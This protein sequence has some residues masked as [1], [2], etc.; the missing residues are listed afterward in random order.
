M[1]QFVRYILTLRLLRSPALSLVDWF[2]RFTLCFFFLG[3]FCHRSK[4]AVGCSDLVVHVYDVHTGQVI[5]DL[6]GHAKIPWVLCFHPSRNTV[7]ASGCLGGQVRVWD[8]VVSRRLSK[9]RLVSCSQ[10]F[11]LVDQLRSSAILVEM[12][13]VRCKFK[14]F[15]YLNQTRSL[16]LMTWIE[17]EEQAFCTYDYFQKVRCLLDGLSN[18]QFPWWS[19]VHVIILEFAFQ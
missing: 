2:F 4:L 15:L 6:K 19:G 17:V 5:R 16:H 18:I 8:I 10:Y 12:W 3:K 14:N 13:T 11:Y 7:L 1:F 9:L